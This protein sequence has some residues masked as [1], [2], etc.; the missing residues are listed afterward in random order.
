VKPWLTMREAVLILEVP[1]TRIQS[2]VTADRIRTRKIMLGR[3]KY[4]L[5]YNTSDLLATEARHAASN[6]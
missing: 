1:R 6:S 5:E 4:R 3:L 2:W